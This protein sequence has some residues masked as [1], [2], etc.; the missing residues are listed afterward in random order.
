MS[1]SELAE[2]RQQLDEYMSKGWIRP[3]SSQWGAPVIFVRKKDGSMRMCID[4]R[5]LNQ[6][7]VRDSYP[8]PRIDDLLDVL[9]EARY[10]SKIDLRSGYH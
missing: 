9:G 5:M 6:R 8:L 10:F 3:S 1:Q 4:Y 2:V 7:T